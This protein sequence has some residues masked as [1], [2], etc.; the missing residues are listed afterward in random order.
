MARTPVQ[1]MNLGIGDDLN[2]WMAADLDQL[3]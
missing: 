3:R 1:S 2:I